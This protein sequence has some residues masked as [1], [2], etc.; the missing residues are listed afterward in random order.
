MRLPG[1][2]ENSL[3]DSW[4]TRVMD[5][6]FRQQG[7]PAYAVDALLRLSFIGRRAFGALVY[8]PAVGVESERWTMDSIFAAASQIAGRPDGLVAVGRCRH[9]AGWCPPQGGALV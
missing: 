6:W 3:P 8:A 1:L 9:L 4:G 7:P 5:D 2:F